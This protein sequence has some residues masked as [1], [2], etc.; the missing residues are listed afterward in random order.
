[1]V[2][3]QVGVVEVETTQSQRGDDVIPIQDDSLVLETDGV[4]VGFQMQALAGEHTAVLRT[5]TLDQFI[6]A[7]QIRQ[8]KSYR[9]TL[10]VQLQLHHR[11]R[12]LRYINTYQLF[13]LSQV[14]IVT[15]GI[16]V[17]CTFRIHVNRIAFHASARHPTRLL[18]FELFFSKLQ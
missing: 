10:G 16:T 3:T 15:S 2:I 1:V 4:L 11:R 6:Q 8:S 7:D 14:L 5:Q 9:D 13:K 12:S 18:E 17:Y